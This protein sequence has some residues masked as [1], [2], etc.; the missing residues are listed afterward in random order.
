LYGGLKT[1][2]GTT[3]KYTNLDKLHKKEVKERYQAKL[4]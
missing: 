3:D 2:E 4:G 1:Q